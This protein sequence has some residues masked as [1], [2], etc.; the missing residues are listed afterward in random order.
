MR[1]QKTNEGYLAHKAGSGRGGQGRQEDGLAPSATD[2][3]PKAASRVFPKG[4]KI[5]RAREWEQQ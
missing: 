5:Q 1:R 3:A 4:Q 2:L